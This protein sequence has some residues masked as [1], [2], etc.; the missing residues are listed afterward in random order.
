MPRMLGALRQKVMRVVATFCMTTLPHAS[1]I[2]PE[3]KLSRHS[4]RG[5]LRSAQHLFAFSRVGSIWRLYR[6]VVRANNASCPGIWRRFF[7]PVASL[8]RRQHAFTVL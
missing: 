3:N 1:S 4:C 7:D 6:H 8:R 2:Q 5:Y